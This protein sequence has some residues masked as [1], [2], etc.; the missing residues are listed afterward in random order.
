MIDGVENVLRYSAMGF[1]LVF[2]FVV[3]LILIKTSKKGK[4]NKIVI[5]RNNS[6]RKYDLNS[7][8]EVIPTVNF[9][10]ISI[11]TVLNRKA[12]E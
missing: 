7:I 1:I 4:I 12:K 8:V 10:N 6:L 2:S 3:S 5:V 11:V 9:E